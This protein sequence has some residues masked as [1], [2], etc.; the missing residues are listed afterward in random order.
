M[1]QPYMS[2]YFMFTPIFSPNQNTDKIT[3]NSAM[4]ALRLKKI[5]FGI[6]A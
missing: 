4:Q 2:S 5:I 1:N 6:L 3:D